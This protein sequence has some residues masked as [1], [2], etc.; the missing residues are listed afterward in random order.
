MHRGCF[1]WTPT[2]PLSDGRTQHPGP[3]VCV[4]LVVFPRVSLASLARPG[5]V[6][7]RSGGPASRMCVV[8]LACPGA[9]V[10]EAGGSGPPGAFWCAPLFL[11]L[12]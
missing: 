12:F 2:P 8:A 7:A 10:A 5:G 4:F 3:R 9:V 1:V 11:L 6:L